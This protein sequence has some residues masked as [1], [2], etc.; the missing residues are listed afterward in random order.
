MWTDA[1]RAMFTPMQWAQGVV[2]SMTGRVISVNHVNLTLSVVTDYERK[3]IVTGDLSDDE[4]PAVACTCHRSRCEH[5][6]AACARLVFLEQ[7][8]RS[9][10][11]G[12]K[13]QREKRE[14]EKSRGR[15]KVQLLPPPEKKQRSTDYRSVAG[16][17][18]LRRACQGGQITRAEAG[19]ALKLA[20]QIRIESL[21]QRNSYM[22][23]TLLCQLL[24]PRTDGRG[25]TRVTI[26]LYPDQLRELSCSEHGL[27]FYGQSRK[28]LCTHVQAGLIFLDS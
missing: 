6:A 24:M 9:D 8:S 7:Q 1:L 20:E 23:Q 3:Y 26:E 16:L 19:Q 11:V 27:I 4:K 28:A 17:F 15:E 13:I 2:D 21:R 22:G 5:A 18:D 10:P 25:Q 12:Q 14:Q